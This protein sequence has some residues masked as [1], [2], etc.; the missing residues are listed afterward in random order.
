MIYVGTSGWFYDHWRGHLYPDDLKKEDYFAYYAERYS[1]VE[2]NSAFYRVPTEA[3]VWTPTATSTTTWGGTRC[4]TQS[5]CGAS[6]RREGCP[7]LEAGAWGAAC[8]P[9]TLAL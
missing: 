7:P 1:T 2:I 8:G 3:M 6:F 9:P 4:G 5:R